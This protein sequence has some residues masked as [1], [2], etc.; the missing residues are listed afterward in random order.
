MVGLLEIKPLGTVQA[1][2]DIQLPHPKGN[3]LPFWGH[4]LCSP[5]ACVENLAVV[6][7][8]Y[9][10]SPMPGPGRWKAVVDSPAVAVKAETARLYPSIRQTT[11]ASWVLQPSS[12]IVPQDPW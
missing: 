7:S 5:A 12:H 11:V 1:A 9:A 10:Y 8:G 3:E 4:P 2:L 6:F